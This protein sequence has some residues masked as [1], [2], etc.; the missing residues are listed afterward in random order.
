MPYY[1]T[2]AYRTVDLEKPL[3]PPYAP[4]GFGGLGDL[5]NT[6]WCSPTNP[7]GSCK[8]VNGVC[9]PMDATTLATFKNLQRQ[10]NRILAA[11]GKSLIGVDGRIGPG[12][13]NG[14]SAALGWLASRSI[15]GRALALLFPPDTVKNLPCDW[16]AQ[17]ADAVGAKMQEAATNLSAP[18]VADPASSKPSQPAP[19][20]G[21]VHPPVDEI[22]SSASGS[23]MGWIPPIIA[24]PLG[25]A[26]LGIGALALYK[27]YKGKGGTRRRTGFAR[28]ARRARRRR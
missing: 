3:A 15:V 20:G 28:K 21:V 17:R 25:L 18:L 23:I 1:P 13:K 7:Q 16:L 4:V 14:V 22:V 9:V 2:M 27:A 5:P 26:A 6:A 11:A 12:T 8:P 19:G 10:T 24:T